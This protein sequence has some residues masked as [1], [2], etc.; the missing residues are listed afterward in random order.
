MKGDR[1][2]IVVDVGGGGTKTYELAATK[3]GRRLE[4]ATA[5]GMVEVAEVTRTGEAVRTGRF[6][7]SRVV[8]LIE[9]PST[10][11]AATRRST[12]RGSKDQASLL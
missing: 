11:V 2:E 5:R 7:A 3:A 6:L 9:H 12:K 1:V 10:D 8:A 4:I